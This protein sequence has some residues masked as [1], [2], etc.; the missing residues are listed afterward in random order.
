MAG[1][2][3]PA[4]GENRMTQKGMQTQNYVT[5]QLSSCA[6]AGEQK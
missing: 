6:L 4:A 2:R 5:A 3:A 1:A